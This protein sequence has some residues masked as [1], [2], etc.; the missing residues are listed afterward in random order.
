METEQPVIP[1]NAGEGES[2]PVTGRVIRSIDERIAELDEKIIQAEDRVK[3]LTLKKGMLMAKKEGR[4]TMGTKEERSAFLK[5]FTKHSGFGLT[6]AQAIA[7]LE[8]VSRSINK[9]NIEGM[10]LLSDAGDSLLAPFMSGGEQ[11]G[12][13]ESTA[14]EE[15]GIE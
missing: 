12:R 10:Q 1:T 7:A 14:D 4:T 3:D 11:A 9:E 15:G 6:Y 13:S 2:Q 5:A 8:K